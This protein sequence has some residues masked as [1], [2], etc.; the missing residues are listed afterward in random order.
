[1]KQW[2]HACV[3]LY[4]SFHFTPQATS[5]HPL[6]WIRPT[7]SCLDII[8]HISESLLNLG[9]EL[10]VVQQQNGVQIDDL[11]IR[12]HVQNLKWHTTRFASWHHHLDNRVKHWLGNAEWCQVI[13]SEVYFDNQERDTDVSHSWAG[14]KEAY[15]WYL[16]DKIQQ[17]FISDIGM[18]WNKRK[19]LDFRLSHSSKQ[20]KEEEIW[21]LTYVAVSALMRPSVK[22]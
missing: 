18:S 5:P 3:S 6:F 8:K 10:C 20:E 16:G 7:V 22:F 12:K 17:V 15:L 14:R 1:M 4:P 2:T 13:N 21:G 11:G 9:H 19:C